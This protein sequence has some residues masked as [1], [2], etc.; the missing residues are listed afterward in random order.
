MFPV[1]TCLCFELTVTTHLSQFRQLLLHNFSRE[2]S[3][4]FGVNR[5]TLRQVILFVCSSYPSPAPLT[6]HP[7]SPAPSFLL[8]FDQNFLRLRGGRGVVTI[9][10][11][12]F[13]HFIC[14]F[15]HDLHR[16]F[17]RCPIGRLRNLSHMS[18]CFRTVGGGGCSCTGVHRLC[19]LSQTLQRIT[20][21]WVSSTGRTLVQ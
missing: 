9:S 19:C 11:S 17:G 21:E 14:C 20:R 10:R 12:T 8:S 2:A 16:C 4:P 6:P 13:D 15:L 7:R 18:H 5:N 3:V 1:S